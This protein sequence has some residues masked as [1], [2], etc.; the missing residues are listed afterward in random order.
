M[1][2]KKIDFISPRITLY[3]HG[4]RSHSSIFSG[5][6]TTIIYFLYIILFSY[7]SLEIV[8]HQNVSS[9]FYNKMI[10]DVG[11]YSLYNSGIF[12]YLQVR[13]KIFEP[14]VIQI[15]GIKSVS[16]SKYSIDGKRENY[17]HYIYSICNKDM[18]SYIN[19][20]N[21]ISII[22]DSLYLNNSF[23]I[24]SFYNSTTKTT[25]KYNEN[26]FI[27]PSIEHGMS[28][29]NYTYYGIIVQK[30][31]NSSLNN[32]SC[33]TEENID[34]KVNE[35]TFDFRL[36]NL[37]VDVLNY[38]QPLIY[39][40]ISITSG[41]SPSN[42]AVNHLNFQPMKVK[43]DN[44]LLL[45]SIHE[46]NTYKFEQN[47]KQT[48]DP[49]SGILGVYYFWMQNNAII[50]ERSYKKL[51]NFLADFG[52]ITKAISMISSV[53]NWIIYKFNLLNDTNSLLKKFID[54]RINNPVIGDNL[55][56]SSINLNSN[57]KN[58]QR[59]IKIGLNEQNN[60]NKFTTKNLNNK[61]YLF[62]KIYNSNDSL[63]KI[64]YKKISFLKFI[65]WNFYCH[66]SKINKINNMSFI[67]EIYK[68]FISV[69]SIFLSILI[70]R[71]FE[72]YKNIFNLNNPHYG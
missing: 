47:E 52:G 37:D 70:L 72:K 50:Y 28:N 7:F 45:N 33:D 62:S 67:Y 39:S 11:H 1:F 69:E 23:C 38:K 55:N 24:E 64:I 8:A 49:I 19:N 59:I 4:Y 6:L 20:Q 58:S 44:G 68:K 2:F 56:N 14:N 32:Y 26:N 57:M 27:Y 9:Y 13:K 29:P 46:L 22:D 12:H 61:V 41:F 42:F 5:V 34:K 17:D 25:I 65:E 66:N 71:K 31:I 51:Q 3:F 21:I 40:F 53:L 15:M 43:T 18:K 30:C 10:N 36:I 54:I 60:N 16:L 35:I 63:E 48:W